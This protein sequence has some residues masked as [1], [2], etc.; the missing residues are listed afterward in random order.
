MTEEDKMMLQRQGLPP[1]SCHKELDIVTARYKLVERYN[2]EVKSG[3]SLSQREVL[4]SIAHLL[5]T[6]QKDGGKILILPLEFVGVNFC[7]SGQ[8][9]HRLH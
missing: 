3:Q 9:A 1:D 6:T 7:T 5:K 8:I 2:T 4:E